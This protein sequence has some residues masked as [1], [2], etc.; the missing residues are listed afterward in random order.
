MSVGTMSLVFSYDMP[1]L[2]TDDGQNVPDSTAKFVLLALADHCNDEGEGA[3]PGVRR[4]CKKTSM[5]NQTVCNALNALRHNGYTT[6]EGKSKADTNNYTI[7]LKKLGF[8]PLEQD[9]SSRQNPTAPAAR[10]ESSVK[11]SIKPQGDYQKFSQKTTDERREMLKLAERMEATIGLTPDFTNS[12][13]EKTVREIV[14]K[15]EK[16][17]SFD[18]YVKW[19]QSGN[20]Y[21]RP[22]PYQI[23]KDPKLI[24]TTW[25]QAFIESAK[26]A[27][28]AMTEPDWMSEMRERAQN[29]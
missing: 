22:K 26:R 27:A 21:N 11:P 23:A 8:Q 18:A 4:L 13:W 19:L 15:E 14:R 3:Y 9:N 7:N 1:N 2:K 28:E 29:V 17:Q 12:K 6:L 25:A 16:G 5:S 10:T 24:L 20:D